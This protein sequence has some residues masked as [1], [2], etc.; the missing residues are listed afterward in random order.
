MTPEPNAALYEAML[1]LR[2]LGVVVASTAALTPLGVTLYARYYKQQRD[3]GQFTPE[4]HEWP[5]A[6]ELKE[7]DS[8]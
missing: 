7:W 4:G 8:R 3:V 2:W 1:S 5:T 6:D